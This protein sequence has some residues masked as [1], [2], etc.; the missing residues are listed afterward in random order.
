MNQLFERLRLQA[1][2]RDL[3]RRLGGD[4]DQVILRALEL[5][6]PQPASV[7]IQ[8]SEPQENSSGRDSPTPHSR[9]VSGPGAATPGAQPQ[10]HRT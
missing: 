2:I 5:E 10:I 7:N 3:R 4:A 6:W 8:C 9:S 1:H